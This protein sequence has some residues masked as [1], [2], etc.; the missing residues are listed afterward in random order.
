MLLGMDRT[1]AE[2]AAAQLADV[3]DRPDWQAA[4][5]D[6]ARAFVQMARLIDDLE[7]RVAKLEAEKGK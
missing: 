1:H 7:E 6:V 4:A 3:A 2:V 5:R